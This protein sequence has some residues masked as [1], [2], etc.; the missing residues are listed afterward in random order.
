MSGC[1]LRSGGLDLG[2]S[3]ARIAAGRTRRTWGFVDVN[4]EERDGNAA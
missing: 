1:R 2:R 3:G 4:E